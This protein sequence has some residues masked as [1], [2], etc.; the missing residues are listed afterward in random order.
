MD[1]NTIK[2]RLIQRFI[3]EE[4][5]PGIKVT[6]AAKNKS[7]K[8]NQDG[9][10]A[11]EKD[12]TAYD[13]DLKQ[14]DK[15]MSKMAPNKFN[16]AND[17]Q[18]T[19]H[20]EM[21]IMNGQEMIQYDLQPS[22][23]FTK[24]AEEG[25]TGSARM[26]NEGGIGNAEAAWGASS[27]DFGKDLVKRVKSSIKKR[28]D[29]TPTSK[30][31]GDDWEITKD[32]SHKPYAL[33]ENNE[34]NNKTQI[35]ESMKRLKFKN[36]FNGV[37][38]ALKL[39]PESYRVDN[40]EFEMT[41]GNETYRIRWEGN[42]KE[43]NA[44]VLTASDK[45]M[46]TEDMARMK[47]LFGYKSQDTLGLVK[48]NAR[49]DENKV[50]NDIWNK[51]KKLLGE[52]EEIEGQTADKEAPFEE[53]DVNQAAEAKKHVHMGTASTD[54]G[55][56]APK[57]KE[58]HW[59]DNVK[60]QAAE[61]KKHVEG[62]ESTDKGTVAPA[63]K[64]GEWE[65]VKKKAPEATEH[66]NENEEEE[67][68]NLLDTNMTNENEDMDADD[69]DD[70]DVEDTFGSEE[71]EETETEPSDSDIPAEPELGDSSDDEMPAVTSSTLRLLQSPS[72]GEYFI[73]K[74]GKNLKVDD[75]YLDIASNKM[76]GNGAKRA[77]MILSKMQS[78]V[79]SEEL[80][81][82]IFD[83][84]RG[85]SKEDIS[86]KEQE[87]NSRLQQIQDKFAGKTLTF[88]EKGD[89]QQ[90]PFTPEM[91]LKVAAKNNYLG[92]IKTFDKGD[93]VV[94]VYE[95]GQKGMAKLAAGSGISKGV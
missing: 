82:G 93:K 84:M 80:E 1:K 73:E 27:D 5:T 35:K 52:S 87:F 16:Y 76:L 21:E 2:N 59:E 85:G 36:E 54:K 63:P 43:G 67:E 91:A 12:V 75:M 57:P 44:I 72:T 39:I 77:G 53:A 22:K 51:S 56:V 4:A 88:M 41:D 78:S 49:I 38:N 6:D 17:Q 13:K 37:G 26:G 62:S 7:K 92:V 66:L 28:S 74:D 10:K 65:D 42:L 32:K 58:G 23:E 8:I 29:Q 46:V 33:D 20:D 18:K 71:E 69:D 19:Y 15:D 64:Q 81:E 79:D 50:F 47:A 94:L 48:G 34:N 3:F 90:L 30:M 95:P 11:I 25:M 45:K 83:F 68:L 40:K 60:G 89:N 55:T 61:A 14:K 86:A 31:F 9:V 70:A 24:K